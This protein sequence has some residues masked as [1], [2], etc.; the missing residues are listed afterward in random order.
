MDLSRWLHVLRDGTG[1]DE[2]P[3]VGS[4][5]NFPAGKAC[6]ISSIS[7]LCISTCLICRAAL[8][9]PARGAF[10]EQVGVLCPAQ[11]PNHGAESPPAP[12]PLLRSSWATF[13]APWHPKSPDSPRGEGVPSCQGVGREPG[14]LR[15]QAWLRVTPWGVSLAAAAAGSSAGGGFPDFVLSSPPGSSSSLALSVT[16]PLEG[17]DPGPVGFLVPLV[18]FYHFS[19]FLTSHLFP[20]EASAGEGSLR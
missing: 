4:Q 20:P 17:T 18:R 11:Q 19:S 10:W 1:L 14:G 12:S 2:A 9:A 13:G 6:A 15:G 8:P 5:L 7:S 16:H 3:R